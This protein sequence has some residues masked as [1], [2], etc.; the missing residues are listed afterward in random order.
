MTKEVVRLI[1]NVVVVLD[2]HNVAHIVVDLIEPTFVV[3]DDSWVAVQHQQL[4]TVLRMLSTT[5]TMTM[6]RTMNNHLVHNVVVLW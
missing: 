6:S 4:V 3:D 5:W 2:C 1:G